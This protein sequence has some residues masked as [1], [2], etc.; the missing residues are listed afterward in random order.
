MVNFSGGTFTV[1]NFNATIDRQVDVNA[2]NPASL[3]YWAPTFQ[4][5]TT[6]RCTTPNNKS[7]TVGFIQQINTRVQQ[8]YYRCGMTMWDLPSGSNYPINDSETNNAVPWQYDNNQSRITVNQ[9]QTDLDV[10][11]TSTDRP[12]SRASWR[13]PLPPDGVET[14][15]DPDLRRIIRNQGFTT[16][17]AVREV[18]TNNFALLKKVTWQFSL[19]ITVQDPHFAINQTNY[20]DPVAAD[21]GNN[22]AIPNAVLTGPCANQT[23]RLFWSPPPVSRIV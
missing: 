10:Q 12:T 14:G 18:N 5:T 8:N 17:L 7:F 23:E 22:D 16:W 1:Q 19:D 6:V 2:N 11:L 4:A 13:E 9:N 15:K 20:N 21:P 3:Y